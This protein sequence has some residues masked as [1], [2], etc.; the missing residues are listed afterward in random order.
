MTALLGNTILLSYFVTKGERGAALV[1]AIGVASNFVMMVQIFM[2]GFLHGPVFWSTAGFTAVSCFVNAAYVTGALK[3]QSWRFGPWVWKFW[4]TLLGILGLGVFVQVILST[5]AQIQTLTPGITVG[6]AALLV[7]VLENN[8]HLPQTIKGFWGGLSAWTA[9]L[10]FAFQP[11]GQLV[12]NFTD[13]SSLEGLSLG[14]ILLATTGNSLMVPRALYT[15]DAIWLT[16][17]LWGSLMMG[18][19][20][21][22]SMY[23]GQSTAGLRCLHPVMFAIV[24]AVLAVYFIAVFFMDTQVRSM[25][26]SPST[27]LK[28][29]SRNK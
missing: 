20:Q 4:E 24:T 15:R 1:Q 28:T 5:F 29:A 3:E 2:A 21:L 12:C 22:L 26:S 19:A 13:P 16:G 23:L 10:L 14:T 27:A 8:G 17:T 7:V 9:T 25:E 6:L 18:W 11:V